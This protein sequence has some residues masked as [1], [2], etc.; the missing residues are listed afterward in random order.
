M[1][2]YLLLRTNQVPHFIFMNKRRNGKM[3]NVYNKIKWNEKTKRIFLPLNTTIFELFR[4]I[5]G[6]EKSS[7]SNSFCTTRQPVWRSW[8]FKLCVSGYKCFHVL[9]SFDTENFVP[10]QDWKMEDASFGSCKWSCLGLWLLPSNDQVILEDDHESVHHSK[11]K[12]INRRR[13]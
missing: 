13:T 6:L 1:V 11:E 3:I 10:S 9:L 8:Y 7:M 4:L 12:M 2:C 5:I